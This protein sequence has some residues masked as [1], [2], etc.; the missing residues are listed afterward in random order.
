MY[1]SGTK[2]LGYFE[3]SLEIPLVKLVSLKVGVYFDLAD[4][5]SYFN[6]RLQRR[7]DSP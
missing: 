4:Y 2:Y 5:Y 7:H 3:G 6:A 1:A